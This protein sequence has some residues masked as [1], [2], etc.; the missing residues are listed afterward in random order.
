[1]IDENASVLD[2]ERAA[3]VIGHR[4]G[5]WARWSVLRHLVASN[6]PLTQR[7]LATWANV[8]QPRISQILRA[9]EDSELVEHRPNGWRAT[10][11]RRLLEIISDAYPGAGGERTYW[12]ALDPPRAQALL[13]RHAHPQVAYIGGDVAADLL[14]PWRAPTDALVYA[15]SDIELDPEVFVPVAPGAA[16]LVL[17]R[18][19]DPSLFPEDAS[20]DTVDATQVVFDLLAAG[21]EDRF[22]AAARIT[23]LI[24]GSR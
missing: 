23:D 9:L 24:V 18:P 11:R 17:V 16:T 1:M 7:T 10:D 14:A 21:G 20:S 22:E 13:V 15:R 4:R 2:K 5:S 19:A 6:V 3:A 12:Y 8:S